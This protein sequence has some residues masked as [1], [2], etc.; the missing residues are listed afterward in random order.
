MRPQTFRIALVLALGMGSV[1]A[2]PLGCFD[3]GAPIVA[4]TCQ[5]IE[6]D[7]GCAAKCD[8]SKCLGANTCVANEC[9]LLCDTHLDCHGDQRCAP[10]TADDAV[11]D[12]GLIPDGGG[13]STGV[14][15]CEPSGKAVGF[16][17]A[18]PLG[19]ECD[20]LFACPDGTPCDPKG[21]ASS[22]ACS[23]AQCKALTCRSKG[24]GDA[25]AYCTL[26]DCHADGDCPDGFACGVVRD[27]HLICGKVPKK[28]ADGTTP[29]VDP[30]TYAQNGQTFQEGPV[31]LLRNVCVKRAQCAPCKLD[32]DCSDLVAVDD[33]GSLA[34]TQECVTVKGEGR[35]APR[36][37][38]DAD[39]RADSLCATGHCV[40]RAGA[41]TGSAFCE[42]CRSDLDCGGTAS[43]QKLC[44]VVAG[45]QHAC[46]DASIACATSADC[47]LA[48][49]GKHRGACL[50]ETEQVMQGDPT[51]HHCSFP[52]DATK[53]L[54][55]CW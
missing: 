40:P 14:Q 34:P 8:P 43:N 21:G 30:A 22:G 42:P 38:K 45:D 1:V 39:C 25:T 6:T 15:I 24:V 13:G 55:G 17:V 23:A 19:K 10:A 29:C 33:T 52:Y 54:F 20:V 50:D 47:P 2:A 9:K 49:D 46:V 18:C 41:C 28:P 4:G 7:A 36:C 11:D 16:G 53:Q 44:A 12:A 3:H 27:P 5:G 31:S 51:Y 48:P 37:A 26:S 35:C 32:L